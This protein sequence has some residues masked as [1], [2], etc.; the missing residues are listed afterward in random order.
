MKKIFLFIVLTTIA[1]TTNSCSNDESSDI[2][3]GSITL[4]VN[5][6]YQTFTKIH[7]T[8]TKSPD[9]QDTSLAIYTEDD[10][11]DYGDW[12]SVNFM[13]GIYSDVGPFSYRTEDEQYVRTPNFVIQI[14][15]NGND[16]KLIG[17]FAGEVS[18]P[19]GNLTITEGTFDIQY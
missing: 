11:D 3:N 16:K 10:G 2:V 7:L 12:V 4:K 19:S 17:T 13:K 1:F 14:T 15:S 9:G 6:V 5:G 8:Q 18:S